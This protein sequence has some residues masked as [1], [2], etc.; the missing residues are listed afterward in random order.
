MNNVICSE[1]GHTTKPGLVDEDGRCPLC[2]APGEPGEES[3]P[4]EDG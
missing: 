4:E 2:Q 3:A 1:C